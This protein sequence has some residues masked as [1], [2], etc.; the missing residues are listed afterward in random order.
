MFEHLRFYSNGFPLWCNDLFRFCCTMVLLMMT[1]Q[2]RV[3]YQTNFV[4][5]FVI[6]EPPGV[7]PGQKIISERIRLG[8]KKPKLRCHLTNVTAKVNENENLRSQSTLSHGYV[9][10]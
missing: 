4:I 8:W 6:F 3:H 2:S 5:F 9:A 7:F 10:T 1:G